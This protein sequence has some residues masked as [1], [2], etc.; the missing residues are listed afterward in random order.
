MRQRS[1]TAI[2]SLVILSDLK[3][4]S[5]VQAHNILVSVK[6][7]LRDMLK[8]MPVK[9]CIFDHALEEINAKLKETGRRDNRTAQVGRGIIREY[10]PCNKRAVNILYNGDSHTD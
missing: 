5:W 3:L 10:L 9:S 8:I 6:P 7:S 4:K 1:D 2:I